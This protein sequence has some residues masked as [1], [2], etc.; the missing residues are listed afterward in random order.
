M[1]KNKF[2]LKLFNLLNYKQELQIENGISE[3]FIF[4]KIFALK[5]E[6]DLA[7]EVLLSMDLKIYTNPK[8][9][10]LTVVTSDDW[11]KNTNP[12]AYNKL[13]ETRRVHDAVREIYGTNDEVNQ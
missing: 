4:D 8:T 6:L 2:K 7:K 9:N 3:R 13:I 1:N 10:K 5:A 11:L 12:D